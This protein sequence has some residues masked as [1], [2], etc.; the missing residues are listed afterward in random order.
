MTLEV[1]K[2][3]NA[4]ASF[5]TQLGVIE[6]ATQDSRNDF[7]N[8]EANFIALHSKEAVAVLSGYVNDGL[9]TAGE[10]KE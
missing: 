5:K 2:S 1:V 9:P 6:T 8:I 4:W 10:L 7:N 3:S